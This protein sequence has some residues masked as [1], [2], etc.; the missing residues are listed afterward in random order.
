M[1]SAAI[2]TKN[3]EN[4]I[5]RCLESL[6]WVDEIIIIDSGSTDNTLN[7]CKNYN[8][9]ITSSKWLGFGKTKQLAVSKTSH[10]W[11]LSIDADEEVSRELASK[12][13]LLLK[14][15]DFFGYQI[16]RKSFYLGKKINFS[17][18]QND[19]PLR[20]FN[21]NFGNFNDNP[22]HEKVQLKT[23]NISIIEEPLI[24][25]PYP[26]LESHIAK[27]NSYTSIAAENLHNQN[28]KTFLIVPPLAG[29]FK[30]VKTYFL[31]LGF[32]DG[33]IGL[34]LAIMSSWY[35]FL[36]YLKLWLLQRKL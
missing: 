6:S 35:V 17:G 8:C 2:I 27:I 19:Y 31:K 33:K 7:V 36:K 10:N 13:K 16:R 30:F 11:V 9:S 22:V 34:V 28:R 32:L 23:E 14:S 12:I 20:L 26:N 4:N 24:H 15:N 29:F 18:W 1:I 3:E 21:K 25:Y 5:E